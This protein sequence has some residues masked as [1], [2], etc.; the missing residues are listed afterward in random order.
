MSLNV[1]CC[2]RNHVVK[3][4]IYSRPEEEDARKLSHP[5]VK[6]RIESQS[7][8]IIYWKEYINSDLLEVQIGMT[9]ARRN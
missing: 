9:S 7:S 8:R 5:E 3:T 4:Q 6:T 2:Y 1:S